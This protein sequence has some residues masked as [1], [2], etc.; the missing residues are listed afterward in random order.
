MS[1]IYL[2]YFDSVPNLAEIKEK[3]S[4]NFP[5]KAITNNTIL[6]SADSTEDRISIYNKIV[7]KTQTGIIFVSVFN[8]YYGILP[9]EVWDWLKSRG[10]A[11]KG[12]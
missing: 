11:V 10:V 12:I 1:N 6:V 9:S 3:I 4:N 2:I 8:A 5:H 7:G